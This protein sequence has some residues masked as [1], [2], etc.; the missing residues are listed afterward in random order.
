MRASE[1]GKHS[2]RKRVGKR[3]EEGETPVRER[4]AEAG[5]TQS[6]TGHEEPSG[7]QGGPP[8]KA[9]HYQTTDSEEYR[10]GKVK[11]TAGAE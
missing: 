11:R 1:S 6:T 8:S 5:V 3:G 7:K 10:E 4:K 2:K 9:K